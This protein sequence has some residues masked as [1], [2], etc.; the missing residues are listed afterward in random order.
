MDRKL[1]PKQSLLQHYGCQVD[2]SS[3]CI[4]KESEESWYGVTQPNYSMRS[5]QAESVSSFLVSQKLLIEEC[6]PDY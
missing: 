5:R 6:K 4:V 1:A 2:G 3:T